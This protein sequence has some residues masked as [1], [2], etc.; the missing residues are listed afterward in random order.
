MCI[1]KTREGNPR[2]YPGPSESNIKPLESGYTDSHLVEK[3]LFH[4][5]SHQ[6]ICG[7]QN[8]HSLSCVF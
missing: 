5:R 1:T 7:A 3:S 4:N 8:I 6:P 2:L